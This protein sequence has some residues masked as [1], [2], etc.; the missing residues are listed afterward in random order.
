VEG[1]PIVYV[2]DRMLLI[3]GTSALVRLFDFIFLY[4]GG[5]WTKRK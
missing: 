3:A 2:C 5:G 4:I 1:R